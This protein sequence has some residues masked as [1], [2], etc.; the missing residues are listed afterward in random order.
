MRRF[1]F[2][3][4]FV[5]LA[6]LMSVGIPGAM[7]Q[8]GLPPDGPSIE[9]IEEPIHV[10]KDTSAYD[11]ADNVKRAGDHGCN[12]YWAVF[13]SGYP[14]LPAGVWADNI[15]NQGHITLHNG[16]DGYF[17]CDPYGGC[18]TYLCT[19]HGGL[20]NAWTVKVKW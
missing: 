1:E 7:A 11:Y 12:D 19:K 13:N 15:A 4:V 5:L 3:L 9:A 16:L 6:L 18:K 8:E 10:Y 17:R 20:A 2:R 14:N